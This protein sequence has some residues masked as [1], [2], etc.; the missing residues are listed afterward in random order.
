M[1]SKVDLSRE[2]CGCEA[3]VA[4]TL[5][6][7]VSDPAERLFLSAASDSVT[8]SEE[9][10]LVAPPQRVQNFFSILDPHMEHTR[11]VA[12]DPRGE[13][14]SVGLE[15]DCGMLRGGTGD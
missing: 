5:C 4:G 7:R 10:S 6:V 2:M 1:R 3:R 11:G 15:G 12:R 13:S 8:C 9:S 14:A